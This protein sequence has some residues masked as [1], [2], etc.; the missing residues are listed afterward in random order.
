MEASTK[1]GFPRNV[2]ICFCGKLCF[3][4]DSKPWGGSLVSTNKAD[5][6]FYSDRD[7][8][9][10]SDFSNGKCSVN[11]WIYV[12]QRSTQIFCASRSPGGKYVFQKHVTKED[13]SPRTHLWE[14]YSSTTFGGRLCF[15]KRL[16]MVSPEV[17]IWCEKEHWWKIILSQRCWEIASPVLMFPPRRDGTFFFHRDENT[18]C[19]WGSNIFLKRQLDLPNPPQ[20]TFSGGSFI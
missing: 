8:G 7:V 13:Y 2:W 19:M 20:N 12:L 9:Q 11:D 17:E 6:S 10:L 16:V 4:C 3:V 5:G 1:E 14:Q 18:V 15:H